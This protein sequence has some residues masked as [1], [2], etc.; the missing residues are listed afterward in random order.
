MKRKFLILLTTFSMLLTAI[1][2]VFSVSAAGEANLST[3]INSTSADGTLSLSQNVTVSNHL[4]VAKSITINGANNTYTVPANYTP[5]ILDKNNITVKV[6]NLTVNLGSDGDGD[7]PFAQ[8]RNN[9]TLIFENCTFITSGTR[10]GGYFNFNTGGGTLKMTNCDIQI[11]SKTAT[12]PIFGCYSAGIKADITLTNVTADLTESAP[13]MDA[14]NLIDGN[15]VLLRGSTAVRV[16]DTALMGNGYT[17]KVSDRAT[18]TGAEFTNGTNITVSGYGAP[19]IL[20]GA[21]MRV[22]STSNAQNGLRFL[23]TMPKASATNAISYGIILAKWEDVKSAGAFTVEALDAKGLKYQS[24]DAK[25]ANAGLTFDEDTQTY[26]YSLALVNI[27]ETEF[28]TDFAARAYAVYGTGENAVTLYSSFSERYNVRNLREVA[29]AAYTDVSYTK[30]GDYSTLVRGAFYT[31][32]LKDQYDVIAQY[33]DEAYKTKYATVA[34]VYGSSAD[35]AT[36]IYQESK[37]GVMIR[38][39]VLDLGLSEVLS[40]TQITDI[41]FTGY[42]PSLDNDTVRETWQKFSFSSSIDRY[43]GNCMSYA[44]NSDQIVLTG[45]IFSYLSCGAIQKAQQYVWNNTYIGKIMACLGNHDTIQSMN[46][47]TSEDEELSWSAR[48]AILKSTNATNWVISSG[49][50]A[51]GQHQNS[52]HYSSKLLGT[53]KKVMLIQMDNASRYDELDSNGEKTFGSFENVNAEWLEADLAYARQNG[54]T[55]LLFYHVPINTGNPNDLSVQAHFI[56]DSNSSV[57]NFYNESGYVGAG[58]TVYDLITQNADIIAGSFCGH[59]HSDFYTEI[60]GTGTAAGHVI[61]QYVVTGAAYNYGHLL[62][63]TIQ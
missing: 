34:T 8:I 22:A 31:P 50:T 52:I 60:L 14:F 11:N 48:M 5:F 49:M 37:N 45:D 23:A 15:T 38:E 20:S 1:G 4:K 54:C 57:R 2:T 40:V 42:D 43:I 24:C 30:K 28:S 10:E 61:P 29:N 33:A 26:T 13:F 35:R 32:Y 9:S 19:S 3:L 62:K 18:V 56:G 27:P 47:P 12:A 21:Q 46:L 17:V 36:W 58:D 55:V 41:H 44:A 53:E 63:V 51:S 16:G 7:Q 6:Q 39:V 25:N 59:E